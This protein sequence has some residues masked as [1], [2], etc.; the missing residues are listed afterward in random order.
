MRRVRVVALTAAAALGLVACRGEPGAGPTPI[1]VSAEC[2]AAFE[3]VRQAASPAPASPGPT[4]SPAS[5]P[6]GALF[7]LVDTVPACRNAQEWVEAYRGHP[8][9]ATAGIPPVTALRRI[10]LSAPREEVADSETCR[11]VTVGQP[12]GSPASPTDE[13]G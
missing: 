4:A 7:D 1:P 3:D 10:C 2:S 6:V 9:E 8:L 5:V 13:P 11:E 12:P